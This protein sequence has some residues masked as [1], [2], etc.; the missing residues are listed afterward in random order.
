MR[1]KSHKHANPLQQAREEQR[2][3]MS[4]AQ[5]TFAQSVAI[6]ALRHDDQK[7]HNNWR[8]TAL[9]RAP[10]LVR[11]RPHPNKNRKFHQA[12]P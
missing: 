12:T 2:A 10:T 5:R 7:P 4:K 3:K 1:E 9:L 11:L 8:S 6:G